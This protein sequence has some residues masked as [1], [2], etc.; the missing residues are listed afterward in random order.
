M[1]SDVSEKAS[2]TSIQVP[3]IYKYNDYNAFSLCPDAGR[4]HFYETDPSNSVSSYSKCIELDATSCAE[5]PFW[6]RVELGDEHALKDFIFIRCFSYHPRRGTKLDDEHPWGITSWATRYAS[7]PAK[8]V[9]G[10]ILIPDSWIAAYTMLPRDKSTR[11]TWQGMDVY[12]LA[13]D[14]GNGAAKDNKTREGWRK[15][16]ATLKKFGITPEEIKAARSE[17]EVTSIVPGNVQLADV[18]IGDLLPKLGGSL[19]GC[20]SMPLDV[21]RVHL[22]DKGKV[23]NKYHLCYAGDADTEARVDITQLCNSGYTH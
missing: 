11:Q 13:C 19:R 17:G 2:T 6:W 7:M 3:V 16:Q 9:D 20:T 22:W 1:T 15:K 12:T 5:D 4:M 8:V 23:G 10:T 14:M 21:V 18:C